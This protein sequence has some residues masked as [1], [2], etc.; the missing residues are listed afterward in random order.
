MSYSQQ[1]P[2]AIGWRARVRN[3][4]QVVDQHRHMY[5]SDLRVSARQYAGDFPRNLLLVIVSQIF[6]SIAVWLVKSAIRDAA[7]ELGVSLSDA[8]VGVLADVAVD[9][10]AA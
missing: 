9:A 8:E 3:W 1:Q 10:L 4:L 2:Q 7:S 6:R 5:F